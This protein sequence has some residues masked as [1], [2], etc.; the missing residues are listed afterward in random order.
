MTKSVK[1]GNFQD[2]I[3]KR[4][5]KEEQTKIDQEVALEIKALRA[6][7]QNVK[8]LFEDYMKKHNYG[9]NEM[10]RIL[11]TTPRHTSKIKSG[12]ANLTLASLALLAAKLGQ[13]PVISFKK[14]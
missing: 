13:E 12:K 10:V 4:L 7:Q 1:L 2:I 5:T 6:L 11:E 9:F 8:D 3:D 14:K